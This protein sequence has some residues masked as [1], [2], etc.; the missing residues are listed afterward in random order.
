VSNVYTHSETFASLKNI[1]EE[2]KASLTTAQWLQTLD[3][4]LESAIDPMVT[5]NGCLVDNF[6]AK[7]VAWQSHR[8]SIKF[9]RND[10][11]TLSVA[12][13]NSV[14]T[15]GESKRKHQKSML[16]NR[17]LLF[18]LIAIF[19]RTINNYKRL[20]DP[21]LRISRSRRLL[22]IKHA[23]DRVHSPHLYS[24][25]M[26]VEYFS[27]KALWF[28]ELIMQKYTRLALMNAKRTYKLV[29]YAQRLDDIIQVYLIFLSRAIDR[30]DSR[31]GVLTTFIQTWFYSARSEVQ[32]SCVESQH[33]SY[34]EMLENG[35]HSLTTEADHGYEAVQHLSYVAKQVDPVGILRFSLGIPEFFST[36]DLKK[37][38]I[39]TTNR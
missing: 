33:T 2:V 10:K 6:F 35:V 4:L 18:G 8:P 31:Q 20:H 23:E 17:G 14:T 26:Q 1:K 21:T 32:K 16:L 15:H 24:A 28:K 7:V 27:G 5:A 30:C 11:A 19:L 12:L 36:K 38:E 34:E 25:L 29:N 3:H 39:F 37:L 13:F 22:L 9:S